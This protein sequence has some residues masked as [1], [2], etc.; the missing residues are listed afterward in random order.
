MRGLGR[1][2][3]FRDV[4]LTV[5]RG[6]IL[7][8]AGM[9]G[10]GRT[11]LLRAIFGADAYDAGQITLEGRGVAG[12]SIQGMKRLGAALIPENRKEQSLVLNLSSRK[13]LSLASLKSVDGTA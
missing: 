7:G 4:D 11:E 2:N 1:K 5:H 12:T 8:I 9:L 6:E 3:A 10:S 13:N